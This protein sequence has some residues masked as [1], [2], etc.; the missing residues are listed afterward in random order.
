MQRAAVVMAGLA[1]LCACGSRDDIEQDWKSTMARYKML[2]VFPITEDV[3]PGDVFLDVPPAPG[4]DP[5]PSLLR[6]GS[7]DIDSLRN[8]LAERETGRLFTEAIKTGSS[9]SA[10]GAAAGAGAPSPPTPASTLSAAAT[11]QPGT[12]IQTTTTIKAAPGAPA[13]KAPVDKA[14]PKPSPRTPDALDAETVQTEPPD[15]APAKPPARPGARSASKTVAQSGCPPQK[16]Y[17]PR[18]RRVAL[19]AIEAARVSN[20]QIS[21][22]GPI[23]RIVSSLGLSRENATALQINFDQLET[24]ELD[25]LSAN[26]LLQNTVV[27]WLQ[28]NGMTPATLLG[29]TNLASPDRV[30]NI[31]R[32]GPQHAD[33]DRAAI[34]IANRVLYA[35]VIQYEYLQSS[36]T[37]G[38]LAVDIVKPTI[39]A[40]T[41]LVP[42][43]TAGTSAQPGTTAVATTVG[44]AIDA[45]NAGL[46]N[47]AANSPNQ[48]TPGV[49]TTVGIG[50]YGNVSLSQTYPRPLA[51]GFNAVHS[52]AVRDSLIAYGPEQQDADNQM[53]EARQFCYPTEEADENAP[54]TPIERT[55]CN[56][57]RALQ[58]RQT[59]IVMPTR[60][61]NTTPLSEAALMTPH[62]SGPR[63]LSQ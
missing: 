41:P 21:G 5:Q 40:S 16:T 36:Y 39:G 57:T 8:C 1:V 37:A 44:G 2:P 14:P 18:M 62:T 25:I 32:G 47:T 63:L 10:A 42:A 17:T 53:I 27:S 61:M 35:H 22:A 13:P 58:I 45:I 51:V 33:N 55:I 43:T 23:G 3:Q 30:A 6:L 15:P 56:N 49:R 59:S 52:Y 34:R 11:V 4:A 19:P 50:T 46:A 24:L 20:W 29:L 54:L 28:K 9:P 12:S 38:R 60:C 31:C 48:S 7:F 26:T